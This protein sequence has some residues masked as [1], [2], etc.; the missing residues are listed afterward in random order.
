MYSEDNIRH[1]YRSFWICRE[2]EVYVL[3]SRN[4]YLGKEQARWLKDSL[5]KSTAQY[6]LIFTGR[7]FGLQFINQLEETLSLEREDEQEEGGVEGE[8][9]QPEGTES[10]AAVVTAEDEGEENE[11]VAAPVEEG[12]SDPK[13]KPRKS[14]VSSSRQKALEAT[15][16]EF[17]EDGLGKTSLQ[18]VIIHNY[19]KEF[20]EGY[21]LTDAAAENDNGADGEGGGGDDNSSYNSPLSRSH[22]DSSRD[23]H[24]EDRG[25]GAGEGDEEDLLTEMES[26]TVSH[27]IQATNVHL[28][29]GIVIF[30]STQANDSYLA[31]Y[32]F[33]ETEPI[34]PSS[35]QPSV[36]LAAYCLEVGIGLGS[37]GHKD[38]KCIT[39]P[40]KNSS[41]E[42]IVK[43]G[44]HLLFRSLCPPPADRDPLSVTSD[45]GEVTPPAFSSSPSVPVLTL[46][47]GDE[48]VGEEEQQAAAEQREE[49]EK[50]I[51]S[52]TV[53]EYAESPITSS[54]LLHSDGSLSIKM[55]CVGTGR[56]LYQVHVVSE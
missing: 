24:D 48:D 15:K 47:N 2:I 30:S 51:M 39:S 4:G 28:L 31:T 27:C 36:Q 1:L 18:H 42:R 56:T 34:V 33:S 22:L 32:S 52:V 10:F 54:L 9:P 16:E 7:S 55:K 5:R 46:P 12:N 29:G 41:A 14:T 11:E 8:Q 38:V 3:D 45:E 13:E 44:H 25:A 37:C 26:E 17:D 6:K 49:N 21:P 23:L 19:R 40:H 43:Q 53:E 20:P 35:L 50:R